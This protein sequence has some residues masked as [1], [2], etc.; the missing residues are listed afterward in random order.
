MPAKSV[1]PRLCTHWKSCRAV[2]SRMPH[3]LERLLELGELH[4]REIVADSSAMMTTGSSIV[5]RVVAAQLFGSRGGCATAAQRVITSRPLSNPV[6]PSP[7]SSY[8]SQTRMV[9]REVLDSGLRLITET[10][11]H[12]RSVSHRRLA[13]ARLPARERTTESG[14]AH[15]VEHMLFKGTD[16]ADRA[17]TSRRR[18]TR[19]AASSTRSRPRN[20]PA[21]TSRC[22]T[23]TCRWRSTSSP[24]S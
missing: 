7:T 12:V 3:R 1:T 15:F 13:D 2:K 4:F 23:S 17:K 19:S 9:T 22:S 5:L 21:T 14:I 24:T 20:T 11:P 8:G 16:D 6:I 10:M 18:S